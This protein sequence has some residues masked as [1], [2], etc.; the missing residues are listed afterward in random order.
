MG[1]FSSLTPAVQIILVLSVLALI[2]W[3][4]YLTYKLKALTF[5]VSGKGYRF[6][7]ATGQIPAS[8]PF[9]GSAIKLPA[10]IKKL[11]GSY[12]DNDKL[13]YLGVFRQG[14]KL[15]S[16]DIFDREELEEFFTT[17]TPDEK[18]RAV[19]IM[20]F[21]LH[22]SIKQINNKLEELDQG[23]MIR[24]VFD[25]DV[26]AIYYYKLNIKSKYLIGVT[27]DEGLVNICDNIMEEAAENIFDRYKNK[28]AIPTASI[29]KPVK[30]KKP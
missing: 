20:A 8:F 14:R 3:G 23:G 18:L 5:E 4:F 17:L 1:S 26:G 13:R 27:L 16:K 25:V 2:L 15:Y 29:A 10:D 11:V 6:W 24:G 21:E 12:V 9:K 7:G 19:E 28:G 30:S 22:E